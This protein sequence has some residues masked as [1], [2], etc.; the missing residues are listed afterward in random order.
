L[1]A[2]R[3]N[4]GATFNFK[5]RFSAERELSADIDALCYSIGG[6]QSV[7]N[8]S[9][10][11]QKYT[12][13]FRA[14]IPT[15]IEIISA[16]ADYTERLKNVQLGVGWKLSKTNTNNLSDYEVW[17]VSGWKPDLGKSNHFLYGET[18]HSL[19]MTAQTTLRKF[20][21]QGGLR[22]EG[23]AYDGRQL[24]KDSAFS[25][26]YNS[27]FPT[28]TALFESD[29]ANLFSASVGRRIERPQFQ[30]LN[31]FLFIINKYT[32][33]QGNPY[34]RPAFTWNME[35]SHT[36]K[37][38]LQTALLYSVTKDYFSQLFP[39]DSNGIVI[40]TEGNLSRMQNIGAAVSLQ[41]A[42]RKWWSF[43][44]QTVI[45]RKKLEGIVMRPM[46]ATITQYQ[47]NLNNQ[48]RFSKGWSAEVNGIYNSASQEDIQEILD[49]Y[50]QL[51][52]GIA[53][54]IAQ[55]KGTF[56]LSFR[57]VFYT[58]WLKG[59]SYFNRATEYFK[60]TSD[61]RV[62]TFGFTWRFGKAYKTEKRSEGAARDEVQR[63]GT[64]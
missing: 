7:E 35:L 26:R 63:V 13:S 15:T 21:L 14:N 10:T 1:Q 28:V 16:K 17:E 38:A 23:T 61:T 4:I 25:R 52:F 22:F 9:I 33:Q 34:Y 46:K 41:L 42:P 45:N 59:V 56:K 47:I 30:K 24:Q 2:D 37:N 64:D 12:E 6:S 44:F 53:K 60:L 40:Y 51:S 20:S 48:L 27:L 18:I 55:N 43:S 32:Y 57:D 5:H 62:A 19:Y 49:P 11:P 50:G 54:S 39:T 31:P 58:N 36:Y 3:Y 29:S 8:N